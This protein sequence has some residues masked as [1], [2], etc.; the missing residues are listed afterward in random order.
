MASG[1]YR[2]PLRYKWISNLLEL[3]RDVGGSQD[4]RSGCAVA[5]ARTCVCAPTS[6]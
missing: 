6:R 3:C 1:V 2:E 5:G 4:D